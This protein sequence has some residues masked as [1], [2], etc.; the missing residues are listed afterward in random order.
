MKL[1]RPFR[2]GGVKEVDFF[3]VIFEGNALQI[4]QEINAKNAPMN[5]S[6]HPVE[7]IQQETSSFNLDHHVK[8]NANVAAYTL[9]REAINHVLD[10]V[11]LEDILSSIC[12]IVNRE[13]NCP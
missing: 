2:G 9:A 4:N 13:S 12:G 11:W 8:R 3:D 10:F 7:G 1:L 6:G 5:R